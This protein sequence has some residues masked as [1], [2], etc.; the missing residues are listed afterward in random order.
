MSGMVA[1][2]A[3]NAVAANLLMVVAFLHLE[4]QRGNQRIRSGRRTLHCIYGHH[5][6]YSLRNGSSACLPCSKIMGFFSARAC[7]ISSWQ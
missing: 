7:L 6:L 3:R 4:W 5:G 2:F 1:W